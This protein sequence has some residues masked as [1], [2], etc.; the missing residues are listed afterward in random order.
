MTNQGE[1]VWEA[2]Y[3]ATLV[4]D[5]PVAARPAEGA[6]K[7]KTSIFVAN[8]P[9]DSVSERTVAE[10]VSDFE[11]SGGS[12]DCFHRCHLIKSRAQTCHSL[13]PCS[14][15]FSHPSL[16]HFS[17]HPGRCLPPFYLRFQ[18]ESMRL[19]TNRRYAFLEV[20]DEETQQAV[21]AHLT[22]LDLGI[23]VEA[24]WEQR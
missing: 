9:P 12:G 21:I 2:G 17:T 16:P 7:S 14:S 1:R 19:M 15:F 10:W 24:A 5:T 8:I 13:M 20:A 18:V 22:G 11:V 4:H 3:D 23:T 6:T